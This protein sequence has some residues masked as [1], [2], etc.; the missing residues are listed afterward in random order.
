MKKK[1]TQ[2]ASLNIISAII[3]FGLNFFLARN[4]GNEF[5]GEFSLFNAKIALLGLIFIIIPSN[6][7]VVKIQ[8][9]EKFKSVY[10]SFY[11]L[12]G[13]IFLFELIVSNR[14]HYI[15]LP[16]LTIFLF[17]YPTF[18][19][20]FFDC[21]LQA[22][23][24]LNV[25]YVVLFFQVLVKT[26]TFFLA[27][28]TGFINNLGDVVFSIGIGNFISL[29]ALF[30]FFRNKYFYRIKII[31]A[32]KYIVSNLKYF[33][34]YYLNNIIKSL[35][36]NFYIF[37]FN[38]ILNKSQLGLFSLFIKAQSFSFSLF[39]TLEAFLMNRNNNKE[40]YTKIYVKKH[41]LAMITVIMTF[42]VTIIYMYLLNY[43]FYFLESVV[44]GM[45]SI[46]YIDLLMLRT[47]LIL[48][49]NNSSLNL[50][51][52]IEMITMFIVITVIHHHFIQLSVLLCIFLVFF[53]SLLRVLVLRSIIKINRREN[54]Y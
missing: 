43:K 19:L 20:N 11:I 41:F 33:K 27:F 5:F 39:R 49:Y 28:E 15:H 17:S 14:F 21:A 48:S 31:Y 44:L 30:L 7:A 10:F 2:I 1:L 37:M 34:G 9:D 26:G 54:Y 46:L 53:S 24:K 45:G 35:A 16:V 25:F 38:S 47:Q 29:I 12:G 6:Y 18:F 36:D 8:D 4:F 50:S 13:I 42:L 32:I 40:Y 23:N 51:M 3:N 22:D 52:I